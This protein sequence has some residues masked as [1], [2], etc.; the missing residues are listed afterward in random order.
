MKGVGSTKSAIEWRGL[1][2]AAGALLLAAA[3][4]AAPAAASSPASGIATATAPCGSTS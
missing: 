4:T 1:R 3:V 2:S